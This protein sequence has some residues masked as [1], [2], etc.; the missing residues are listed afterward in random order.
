[1][2]WRCSGDCSQ[3]LGGAGLRLRLRGCGDSA[4][5][6]LEEGRGETLE[7]LERDGLGRSL[8]ACGWEEIRGLREETELFP[9]PETRASAPDSISIEIILQNAYSSALL[10]VFPAAILLSL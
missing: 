4:L 3:G 10:V 6:G 8:T 9:V 1:M 7:D 2:R 5:R